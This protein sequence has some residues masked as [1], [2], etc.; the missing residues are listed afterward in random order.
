MSIPSKWQYFE[1]PGMRIFVIQNLTI[2]ISCWLWTHTSLG[3]NLT[4]EA[5]PCPL[6]N[7]LFLGNTEYTWV[8]G[9]NHAFYFVSPFQH[10]G[11]K[12][13]F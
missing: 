4:N 9:R 5:R 8:A 6:G 1:L 13:D 10:S 11:L 3:H 12:F 2:T 7:I